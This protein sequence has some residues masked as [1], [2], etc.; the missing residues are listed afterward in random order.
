MWK[1]KKN[2]ISGPEIPGDK[3]QMRFLGE[4]ISVEKLVGPNTGGKNNSCSEERPAVETNLANFRG[5]SY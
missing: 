1:T 4:E 5:N 3:E 2:Y